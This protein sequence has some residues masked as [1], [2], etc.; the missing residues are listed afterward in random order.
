MITPR[1]SSVIACEHFS[2]IPHSLQTI[3]LFYCS[4][5][6]IISHWGENKFRYSWKF[7]N[8]VTDCCEWLSTSICYPHKCYFSCEFWYL[9]HKTN[10]MFGIWYIFLGNNSTL[11]TIYQWPM[12]LRQ[13]IYIRFHFQYNNFGLSFT[14]LVKLL[15]QLQWRLVNLCSGLSGDRFFLERNLSA[16]PYSNYMPRHKLSVM[17]II[18]WHTWHGQFFTLWQS[19]F[20]YAAIRCSKQ[21]LCHASKYFHIDDMRVPRVP[22]GMIFILIILLNRCGKQGTK[23]SQWYYV[24]AKYKIVCVLYV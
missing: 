11:L 3:V 19:T 23:K 9:E 7:W 4:V 24:V 17:T 21:E 22:R 6:P 5:I 10:N 12:L 13:V 20:H 16:L 8:A 18:R 1:L 15:L 2:A 14:W